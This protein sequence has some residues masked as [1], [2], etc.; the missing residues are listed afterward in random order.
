MSRSKFS[1]RYCGYCNKPTRMELMGE[2][3]TS[4]EKAWCRCTRCHHMT[5]INA[6][7]MQAV[8]DAGLDGAPATTY[9][10][11]LTFKVGEAIFHSEWNDRGKVLSKVRTSS[12]SQ[13]IIVSFEK[14]GQK[15]LIENLQ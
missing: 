10:P 8:A 13:A 4:P 9:T 14:E 1:Q 15:T 11:E 7:E 2:M 3:A 12:G 6:K 5:L